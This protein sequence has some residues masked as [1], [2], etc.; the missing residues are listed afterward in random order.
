MSDILDVLKVVF[1]ILLFLP[2]IIVS[3]MLILA[4]WVILFAKFLGVEIK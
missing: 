1:L 4:M 3:F 2:P